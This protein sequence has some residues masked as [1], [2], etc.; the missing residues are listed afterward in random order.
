METL[1]IDDDTPIDAKILSGAIENAQKK[2][3]SKNFQARKNTLEYDD[4][5]NVQRE[6]IYKQRRQVLDGEEHGAVHPQH[7]PPLD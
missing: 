4:V 3:E 1:K 2:V 5:M 7:D 6:V